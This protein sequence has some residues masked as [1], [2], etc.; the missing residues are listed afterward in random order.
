[1]PADVRHTRID[2]A[3]INRSD[4]FN[5]ALHQVAGRLD[6]ILRLQ[7]IGIFCETPWQPLR[8]RRLESNCSVTNARMQIPSRL[9]S[10]LSNFR[11]EPVYSGERESVCGKSTEHHHRSGEQGE[12]SLPN[13]DLFW[14]IKFRS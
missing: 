3:K 2:F 1:M 6:D 14:P 12:P 9:Q 4:H 13:G 7:R 10:R 11:R 5:C 8:T